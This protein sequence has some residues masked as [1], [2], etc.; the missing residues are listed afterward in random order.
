MALSVSFYPFPTLETERLVLRQ[1]SMNDL[2][3]IYKLRTNVD[4]MRHIGKPINSSKNEIVEIIIKIENGIK[5]NTAI[6]WAI[7]IKGN[8]T[9]LGTIGFHNIYFTHYR[10]EIGYMIMPE[11]W[12][13]GIVTE[14][15]SKV[16]DFGFSQLKLHSIEALISPEN[17]GS[18]RVLLKNNFVKEA[19]FKE[20][21]FFDGKFLDT[22]VYSILNKK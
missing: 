5:E 21:Y 22:A 1:I 16:V 17:I 10:A 19:F 13:K 18:S 20:N 3:D 9:L 4:A 15:V 6:G 8:N 7:T 14:A 2:E 11:F 12:G